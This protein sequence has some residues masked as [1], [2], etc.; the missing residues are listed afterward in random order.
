[1]EYTTKFT[2][3]DFDEVV[4]VLKSQNINDNSPIIIGSKEQ[5]N[6]FYEK[7]FWPAME[8]AMI[9]YIESRNR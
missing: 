6:A 5:I 1:M 2:N 8:R 3:G 4:R 9:V 7:E